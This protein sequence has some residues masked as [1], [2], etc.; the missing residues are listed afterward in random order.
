[1]KVALPFA[2]EIVK[3]FANTARVFVDDEALEVTRSAG[4]L[5]AATGVVSRPGLGVVRLQTH[6][7]LRPL[8][9]G[10]GS[11]TR[12]LGLAVPTEEEATSAASP[13]GS[14]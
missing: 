7:P 12:L 2:I 14:A 10:N 5:L 9:L 6:P 11:D 13:E 8:D 3:G 4:G 1:M